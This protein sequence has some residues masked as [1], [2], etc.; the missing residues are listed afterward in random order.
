MRNRSSASWGF[1]EQ[2]GAHEGQGPA[3]RPDV[4]GQAAEERLRGLVA[5]CDAR[6]QEPNA[7]RTRPP[8]QRPKESA[9]ESSP[10]KL[11][12]HCDLPDE[13]RVVSARW[14][15]GDDKSGRRPAGLCDEAGLGEVCGH[16]NVRVRAVELEGAGRLHELPQSAS[17]RRIGVADLHE[18]YSPTPGGAGIDRWNQTVREL[19]AAIVA[20]KLDAAA[21]IA[22][23]TITPSRLEKQQESVTACAAIDLR[24]Q[25]RAGDERAGCS[26]GGQATRR[27][28]RTSAEPPPTATHVSGFRS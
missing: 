19:N 6:F 13:D 25:E 7:Q 9:P 10:T 24:P 28:Q 21:L 3:V 2:F 18:L 26:P 5:G 15:I 27:G 23:A 8:D 17:V 16:Q 11:R 14:A 4:P 12:R 1:R 22:V 20:C